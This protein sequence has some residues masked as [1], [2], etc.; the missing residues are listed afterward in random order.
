V[1]GQKF[2][3]ADACNDQ[4]DA[5]ETHYRCRF[6]E[7]IHAE[8]RRTDSTD[9]GPHRIGA[10]DRQIAQGKAEQ[11]DTDD[12]AAGGENSGGDAGKA[13]GIFEPDGPADFEE[14]GENENNPGHDDHPLMFDRAVPDLS[15][16]AWE[17]W[18]PS[19]NDL[20]KDQGRNWQEGEWMSNFEG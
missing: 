8:E 18:R 7:D 5:D 17:A 15:G 19:S 13:I 16:N 14:T 6:A 20:C 12:H 4:P 11:N 1:L 3:P 9:A 10:A 2:Q